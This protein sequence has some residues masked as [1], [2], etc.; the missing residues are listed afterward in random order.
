ML[1]CPRCGQQ[2]ARRSRRVGVWEH[3]A[4]VLHLYPFRCQLCTARFRAFQGRHHSQHRGDRR[5]YDRLLVRVPVLISAGGIQAEGETVDLSLTGCSLRTEA[6]HPAGSTVQLRLRLG[7]GGEVAI[8]AA[9][10][11][12]Q[13]EGGMGVHF[14]QVAPPERERLSR[15]LARFLRPTGRARRGAG[16]PR[17]ELVVAAAVGLGVILVVLFLMGRLGPPPIR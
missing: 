9:L 7:Q 2:A 10:V 12:S 5:E 14:T 11:K 4:S 16:R 8:Q 3:V 13:R 17:P 15:Y 1:R 6:A